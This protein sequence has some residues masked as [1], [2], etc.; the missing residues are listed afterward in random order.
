MT[1]GATTDKCD[2]YTFVNKTL[3]FTIK[4]R[5]HLQRPLYLSE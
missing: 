3:S 1:G 2:R 5:P 4:C